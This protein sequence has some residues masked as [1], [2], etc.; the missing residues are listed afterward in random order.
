[1]GLP[2]IFRMTPADLDAALV[3][4]RRSFQQPWSRHM[5]L[6]DML[7]NELATY[8]AVRP[9]PGD[10][11]RLPALLAY[12][13]IWM[14]Y[15]EAHVATIASHPDYRHQGLGHFLLLGLLKEA[16]R[17]G[18]VRST[19]EVRRSNTAAQ[20]LYERLGYLMAGV[21]TRYYRDGEDALIMTTEPLESPEMIARLDAEWERA[22]TRLAEV[23]G[24]E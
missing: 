17:G 16:R 24:T 13:A 1:M 12:G 14:M 22:V 18:A 6:T 2:E 5:Y 3:I 10:A 15:D 20:C 21:R 9:H 19:L 11:A 4:E 8:L 7:H 23:F